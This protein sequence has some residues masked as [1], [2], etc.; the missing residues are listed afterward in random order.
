V[1]NAPRPDQAERDKKDRKQLRQ[2]V[3][4]DA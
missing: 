3:D 4:H 2:P 1:R